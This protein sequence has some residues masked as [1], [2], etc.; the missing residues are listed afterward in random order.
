MNSLSQYPKT[1][2]D[3]VSDDRKRLKER[4]LQSLLIFKIGTLPIV[5]PNATVLVAEEVKHNLGYIPAVIAYWT[6]DNEEYARVPFTDFPT[7]NT[8]KVVTVSASATTLTFTVAIRDLIGLGTSPAVS[9][10]IK[11][12][13]FRERA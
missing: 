9:G 13:I 8:V 2:Y 7:A 5:K 1:Q 4:E 6:E 11:Y 12:Y 10:T 3:L